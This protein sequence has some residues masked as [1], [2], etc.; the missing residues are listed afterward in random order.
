MNPSDILKECQESGV[1]LGVDD[2][3]FYV[4]GNKRSVEKLVPAI[5][6]HKPALIQLL[7]GKSIPEEKPNTKSTLPAFETESKLLDN[8]QST[9]EELVSKYPHRCRFSKPISLNSK[10]DR[11]WDYQHGRWAEEQ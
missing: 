11:I 9:S 1:V 7:I 4:R 6:A 8:Q 5:K 10:P 3:G 2:Q